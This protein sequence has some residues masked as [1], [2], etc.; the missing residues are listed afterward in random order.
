MK[1]LRL[2]LKAKVTLFGVGVLVVVVLA[3]ALFAGRMLRADTERL[4]GEQQLSMTKLIAAQ[5]DERV[6]DRLRALSTVAAAINAELLADPKAL[7]AMLERRELLVR[8]FNRGGFVVDAGGTALASVPLSAGR[9]GLNFMDKPHTVAVLKSGRPLVGQP[10]IG[11][12][13]GKPVFVM[14]APIKAPDGKVIGALMGATDLGAPNFLD[15]VTS[16]TVGRSGGYF[17]LAP[18][19]RAIVAATDKTRVME[20]FPATGVNPAVDRFTLQDE[21]S[22]V[23]VNARGVEVLSS[24]KTIPTANWQLV[25]SL[26]MDELLEPIVTTRYRLLVVAL[27]LTAIAALVGWWFA[28]RELDPVAVTA[29]QLAASASS[30]SMAVPMIL[31][32]DDELGELFTAFSSHLAALKARE[33]VLNRTSQLAKIGGWE[34][35]PATDRRVWS[36]QLLKMLEI[37]P[38]VS[39]ASSE[40]VRKFYT[41]EGQQ[42]VSDAQVAAVANGTPWDLE[43]SMITARGRPIWART[44]GIAEQVDGVTVKL[45]GTVH[46][47]TDRK[48]MEL[49]LR[50]SREF[51]E[52]TLNA[53]GQGLT[54]TSRAGLLEYANPAAAKMLGLPAELLVGKATPDLILAADQKLLEQVH[55]ERRVGKRSIYEA[56]LRRPDGTTL[57]VSISSAPRWRDGEF[58]GSIAVMS[59]LSERRKL[60]LELNEQRDFAADVLASISEGIAVTNMEGR[61]EFVNPAFAAVVG[62]EVTQLIGMMP[63]DISP[64]EERVRSSE[65]RARRRDGVSSQYESRWLKADGSPVDVL[66]SVSPRKRDGLVTGGLIVVTDVT[67]RKKMEMLLAKERDFAQH[68]LNTMGQ[69]IAVSDAEG[70]FEFINRAYAEL[71]GRGGEDITGLAID[72][73][74]PIEESLVVAEQRALRVKGLTSTYETAVIRQDGKKMPIEITAA[75][76]FADGKFIGSTAVVTDLTDRRKLEQQLR[77]QRAFAEGVISAMGQGVGVSD[78]DAVLVY[79]NKAYAALLGRTVEQVVGCRIHDLLPPDERPRL[80]EQ[81]QRRSQGETVTYESRRLHADGH[82]VPVLVNATPRNIDG[83]Y[84]GGIAVITDLTEQR[85]AERILRESEA[86]FRSLMEDV[87][88][89]AVQGYRFDGTVIFWNRA[90]EILYGYSA[91]EAMGRNLLD[92][93]IPEAVADDVRAAVAEM[94]RSLVPLPAEELVLRRKDGSAVTVFSSHGVTQPES[95]EPEFFCLDIDLSSQK[96]AE[97]AREVLEAKLR[98]SQKM[99]AIGT[100]AGGIA[101]DFNNILATILGNVELARHVKTNDAEV[102]TSLEEIRKAGMRARD[103]VGQILSFGR[104]QA[105]DFKNIDLEYIVNESARLLRATMPGNI[106]LDVQCQRRLR[107]IAGDATQLQ[108][109]VINLVTNAMQAIRAAGSGSGNIAVRLDMV[110]LDAEMVLREPALNALH[111]RHS[112]TTVRLSVVDS[113]PGMDADTLARVFE[114]FFTTKSVDEGTGLGLAVVHGIVQGH[115]GVVTVRSERGKG[116]SFVLY[117]AAASGAAVDSSKLRAI[118]RSDEPAPIATSAAATPTST[119]TAAHVLYLDDDE[120][121]AMLVTRLLERRGYRLSAFTDQRAALNALRKDPNG[122]DLVVTDYNM[123]GMSGLDV[124]RE[125]RSIRA[126][127]PVAVA[128]GFVDEKLQALSVDAGVVEVIFKAHVV[129][130][131]CDAVQRLVNRDGG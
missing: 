29:R 98:Q 123:P 43:V 20:R 41:P 27:L 62:R 74:T 33:D 25:A 89:I 18:E 38:P 75:P 58:D 16:S 60:E 37:E 13:L 3:L 109:I 47:I 120:A 94:G 84:A 21:A 93:I 112:G 127:L 49:A 130:D 14:A 28:K 26:P 116:T 80:D 105:T 121:L 35:E 83:K 11:K 61:F 131:F 45:I 97:A 99:E 51:A 65:T 2:S 48:N 104:R 113:G 77:E 115:G 22:A 79:A 101:H 128:S 67:A 122:F 36:L 40:E 50:A 19:S 66:V 17:I 32:R 81:L 1:S 111:E 86:R 71:L 76:R 96:H 69:G 64:P 117:F 106:S 39:P 59:D 68:I 9:I 92:L 54:V 7:Q 23:L 108:Q 88:S 102:V 70:R 53:M 91:E 15:I 100:L 110:E 118:A 24:L 10:T 12:T 114:P 31:K 73:V 90:S 6:A 103:L 85:R 5:I 34:M 72:V 57:P 4:I 78:K 42:A 44:Q 55:A 129:E 56:R 124:A 63:E 87:S 95:R 46:D 52:Q 30:G 82:V 8:L 107:P 119:A 126:D 125:V